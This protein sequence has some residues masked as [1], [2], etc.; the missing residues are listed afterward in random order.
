MSDDHAD[1]TRRDVLGSLASIATLQRR[2]QLERTK[3]ADI[4]EYGRATH[5]E[6][7][8]LMACARSGVSP[9]GTTLYVTTFPCHNCARHIIAAGISKVVYVEPYPKS[10]AGKL[11]GD[12]VEL[13]ETAE[14]PTTGEKIPFVPFLGIGP[15]RYLD[16]FSMEMGNGSRRVRK[17]DDGFGLYTD[18]KRSGARG[19]R[20]PLLPT[21]YIEREELAVKEIHETMERLEGGLL[22]R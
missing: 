22:W 19:P 13:G 6:M 2:S 12:A 9:I 8:A 17:D 10:R 14:I 11:H 5:G 20:V 21:S 1:V 16:F 3:L 18:F 7:D 15:R 4:T